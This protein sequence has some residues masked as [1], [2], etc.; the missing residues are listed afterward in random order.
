MWAPFQALPRPSATGKRPHFA[1]RPRRFTTWRLSERWPKE[2]R[3][4]LPGTY[5][6][7]PSRPRRERGVNGAEKEGGRVPEAVGAPEA[8]RASRRRR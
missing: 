4:C 3:F 2:A 8:P 5:C 6:G 7:G 1:R